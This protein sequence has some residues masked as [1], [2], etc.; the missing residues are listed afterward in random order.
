MSIF[1]EYGA[2]KKRHFC[3]QEKIHKFIYG[4]RR[5]TSPKNVIFS[6]LS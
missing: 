3:I 2:F 5:I 1:E 6:Y 4:I